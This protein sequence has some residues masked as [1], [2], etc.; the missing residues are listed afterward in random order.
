MACKLTLSEIQEATSGK[1]LSQKNA[2]FEGVGTDTRRDL[3]HQVFI[4]LKGENF[5]AH[6]FLDSAVEKGAQCLLIH[7]AQGASSELLE[8]VSVV[9][10]D[11]TLKAL[12][13][14]GRFVRKRENP[15]VIAITGSNGKTSTKEFVAQILSTCKRTHWSKGSFNNHWGVPLTLLDMDQGCEIAVVEMGMNDYGE[16]E[17]LVDIAEPNCVCVTNV[18]SAHIGFFKSLENIAKA[19]EEI[20]RFSAEGTTAVFNLDNYYT[21]QMLQNWIKLRGKEEVLRFSRAK[22]AHA[23]VNLD[24]TKQSKQGIAVK[25]QI[26]GISGEAQIPLFGSHNL[27]NIMAAACLALSAEIPAEKIWQSLPKLKTAWGRSHW[28]DHATTG[29]RILFD[30]Y[31]ANP[32]SFKSLMSNLKSLDEPGKLIGCFG[33]MLELGDLSME[34]HENLGTELG[35]C[36]FERLWFFGPSAEAFRRGYLREGS[37][38]SLF[39][40]ENYDETIA[41]KLRGEI[42]ADSLVVLKGSRGMR[43]ERL[44]PESIPDKTS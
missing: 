38:K 11:D 9:L 2:N 25:G 20:Y 42:S 4:A 8:K 33:E 18:G 39:T 22:D 14:L 40:S 31:N 6:K 35:R 36:G 41:H 26:G 5:D 21:S 1:I 30:G 32:D 17:Q 23:E 34:A 16:I 24:I 7:E 37:E 27:E 19:K 13:N 15:Q 29:A 43:V 44:L 12:Q 3:S 10:V 28:L